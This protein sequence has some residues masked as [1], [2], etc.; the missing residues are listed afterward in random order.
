MPDH[1]SY[2]GPHTGWEWRWVSQRE[3]KNCWEIWISSG[4]LRHLEFVL[5]LQS[6]ILGTASCSSTMGCCVPSA[7]SS[8][9]WIS[10]PTCTPSRASHKLHRVEHTPPGLNCLGGRQLVAGGSHSRAVLTHP[11][12]VH[13]DLKQQSQLGVNPAFLYLTLLD[14]WNRTRKGIIIKCLLRVDVCSSLV[15]RH[16]SGLELKGCSTVELYRSTQDS[17]NEKKMERERFGKAGSSKKSTWGN[18]SRHQQAW[19]SHVGPWSS[20]YQM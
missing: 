8:T 9:Q 17:D 12:V 15:C 2:W 18:W 3:E 1:N 14:I 6:R 4:F 11:Y 16:E 10:P 7:S 19:Y 13:A 20:C 5:S